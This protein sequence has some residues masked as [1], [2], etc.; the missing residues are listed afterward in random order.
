[1]IMN[2]VKSKKSGHTERLSG[3]NINNERIIDSGASHHMTGCL[4]LLINVQ[5]IVP[6]AVELSLDIEAFA[7]NFFLMFCLFL[8]CNA[9]LFQLNV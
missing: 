9:P 2:M 5:D 1:M 4:D 8:K 7:A 6:I 3:K